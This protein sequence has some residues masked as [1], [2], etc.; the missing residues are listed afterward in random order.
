[1]HRSQANRMLAVDIDKVLK[2]TRAELQ[3]KHKTDELD[4]YRSPL[5]ELWQ[6]NLSELETA[7]TADHVKAA[8]VEIDKEGVPADAISSTYDLVE[9]DKR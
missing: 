2:Q 8:L 4:F 5:K 6:S 7:L 1:V 9:G 3:Q